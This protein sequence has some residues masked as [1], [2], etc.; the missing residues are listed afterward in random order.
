M[1]SRITY[2][3]LYVLY[4]FITN[5]AIS[6]IIKWKVVSYIILKVSSSILISVSYECVCFDSDPILTASLLF[7]MHVIINLIFL[8]K[9]GLFRIIF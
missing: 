6:A 9:V 7:E 1:N 3:F 8:E 4:F 2:T 5:A